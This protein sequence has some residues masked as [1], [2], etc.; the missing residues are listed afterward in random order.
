MRRS[1]LLLWPA[2]AAL[3]IAAEWTYFG[4]GEPRD[5]APDLVTGW[6]LIACGLIAWSRLPDNMTGALMAATGFTWFAGNFQTTGLAGID[7]LAAHALYLH[8]GPLVHL[9]LSYPSGRPAGRVGRTAVAVGYGAALVTPVWR[10][11]TATIVLAAL[12]VAVAFHGYASAVGPERRARL[13]GMQATGGLAAVLAGNA[14]ARLDVPTGAADEATLLAYEIALSAGAVALLLGLLRGSWERAAVTDL[15]VELGESRS[16][17]LMDALARELG[18]PTLELGFWLEEAAT[19]VDTDGRRLELPE[20]GSRR[21]VTHIEREGRPLAVFVHDPALRDDPGLVDAVAEA[22][23][24]A[25][26]NARLQ[27]D[28]RVRVAEVQTSRR[29]LVEAGDEERR[30]LEQR[31]REGAER[32]LVSLEQALERSRR[33]AGS[34]T[35]ARIEGTRARLEQT[36]VEL[37]ELAAGLHPRDLTDHGL[38]E[39][40]ASLARRSPVLV[41]LEIPVER[42]PV[43]IEAAA[44]FLCSE[45]LANIAKY[46]SAARVAV[47]VRAGDGIMRVEVAD[48]GVGGADPARGTGLRG[49]ADRIEALGGTLTVESPPGEGTR[50]VAEIPLEP[51]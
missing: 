18:D 46:A 26:S 32:R 41:D 33:Q 50:L 3:G 48:D 10:S 16:G 31:L 28:V 1:L 36:L 19:Y 24:L 7:W 21:A 39:A 44:Y 42:Y 37:H 8:R 23:R 45:A 27:A 2:G 12:L 49:L 6:S 4:W 25:A 29:R 20:P 47:E 22:A 11:E 40:V 9:V 51:M 38:A 30:R 14:I 17:T 15:V 34:E 13:L 5:W 35:A 43:E